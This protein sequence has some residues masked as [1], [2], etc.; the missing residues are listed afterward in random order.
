MDSGGVVGAGAG[1]VGAGVV[2][3]GAVGAGVVGAGVVGAGAG[4][5]GA[6]VVGADAVGAG[7]VG[8]GAVVLGAALDGSPAEAL[9][10]GAERCWAATGATDSRDPA[11]N[12]NPAIRFTVGCFIAGG[13]PAC[14]YNDFVMR[15]SVFTPAPRQ[16]SITCIAS[17]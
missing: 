14:R 8:A 1:V 13:S 15:P 17:P 6:G 3:A 4:V 11:K 16:M 7:V 5:V 12:A 9:G 10:A 2:G